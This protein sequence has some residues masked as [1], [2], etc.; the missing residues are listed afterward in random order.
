MAGP[1]AK[2][3]PKPEDR[4]NQVGELQPEVSRQFDD[5]PAA[6]LVKPQPQ[7][8]KPPLHEEETRPQPGTSKNLN[9]GEARGG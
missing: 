5:A 8:S 2:T 6:D 9:T 4:P 7:A 1:I 3:Q